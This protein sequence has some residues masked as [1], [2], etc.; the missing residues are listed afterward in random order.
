MKII[1]FIEEPSTI[2]SILLHLGEL[3]E[4]PVPT[5]AGGH[6]DWEGGDGDFPA[7]TVMEYDYS[8]TPDY[9]YQD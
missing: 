9:Q 2:V 8:E 7:D 1:A 5:A 4:P 3:T 6:W